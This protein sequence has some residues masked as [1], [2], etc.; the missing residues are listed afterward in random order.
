MHWIIIIVV[1]ALVAMIVRKRFKKDRKLT[2]ADEDEASRF[3]DTLIN[4]DRESIFKFH[5]PTRMTIRKHPEDMVGGE[6]NGINFSLSFTPKTRAPDTGRVWVLL[7]KFEKSPSSSGLSE[8][9]RFEKE[10]SA[11]HP[12]GRRV[13]SI[14]GGIE[15]VKDEPEPTIED[16]KLL[17]DLTNEFNELIEVE[18]GKETVLGPEETEPTPS[19]AT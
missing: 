10:Y 6:W 18:E 3:L 1:V 19:A 8:I 2:E 5:G 15:M 14:I 12:T 4:A 11:K 13:R 17:E 16:K 7:Q 9:W